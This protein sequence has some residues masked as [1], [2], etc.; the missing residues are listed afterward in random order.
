MCLE[1]D[2]FTLG[3]GTVIK[4]WDEGLHG[5][6]EGEKR[7]LTIPPELAYGE[8]GAGSDIPPNATLRFEVELVKIGENEDEVT[9]ES[10]NIFA[11]MDTNNDNKEFKFG[12]M[13]YGINITEEEFDMVMSVFDANGDGVISF[14][15]FIGAISDP[16]N[17][18]RQQY[19]N[20]A[21]AK[22]DVN[23]DGQVT[24]DDVKLRYNCSKHP[25]VVA[26]RK[27]ENEVRGSFMSLWDT[28]E[29]DGIVTIAEFTKYYSDISASVDD[30][31]M[32]ALILINAWNLGT[33]K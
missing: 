4:G 21:Y 22:L 20:A 10:P 30:D 1:L 32:F 31:E 28:Q 17:E 26:G 15:E 2:L 6:C 9:E 11:E 27:T 12:L 3:R 14:D 23:G 29:K 25:D 16:P 8:D 24:I 19:I 33:K 13:D 18:F 5:M 7:L